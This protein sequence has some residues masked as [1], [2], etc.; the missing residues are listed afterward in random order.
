MKKI[1]VIGSS[2]MDLVMNVSEL[3]RP[4]ETVRSV[5]HMWLPGGKGANQAY[6]CGKLGG[7]CTFLSAVGADPYGKTLLASLK[8]VGVDTSGIL[9][10]A[11]SM[12][13][14]AIITVDSTGENSIVLLPGAN[15]LCDRA[16]L[17]GC[18]EALEQSD[19]VLAQLETPLDGVAYILEEA[20]RR[21]KCTILNP[22]PAPEE[23]EILRPVYPFLDYITP[24][25]TELERLTGL[26][27][28]T[29]EQA[30]AAAERLLEWGVKTVLVT[31]GEQGAVYV[32]A[33]CNRHIPAI[34]VQAV[35]TTAAGDTFNA[36]VAVELAAG[37]SIAEALQFA[38]AAAAIS[39]TRKG[40]QPSVPSRTETE[41]VRDAGS[42]QRNTICLG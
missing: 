25:E 2:N 27:V 42:E 19:V 28:D 12:T 41:A 40:A 33:H 36:G 7:D 29:V 21:G 35:D 9:C 6:A 10:G 8:S 17:E 38:I 15:L 11:S 14:M 24:N 1:L 26:P 3:P 34:R 18:F 20:K 13:G 31:M 23:P 16:Y 39:V 5:Q 22:A 32:D 30:C 37:R 4:G